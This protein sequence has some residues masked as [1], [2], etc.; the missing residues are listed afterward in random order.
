MEEK[1]EEQNF[2]FIDQQ[3]LYIELKKCG[4]IIDYVKFAR[5]LKEKYSVKRAYMF[6]GYIKGNERLYD[7]LNESGFECIFKPTMIKEGAIKGNCD[8]ELIL[9]AMRLFPMCDK[10][11]VVTSDGDFRCLVEYLI[12]HNKLKQL[13]VPN[14]RRY[15]ALLKSFREY[16]GYLNDME[17]RLKKESPHRDKTP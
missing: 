7:A 5:Y 14:G 3:N 6:L 10:I 8:S 11:V 16:T 12:F 1:K 17:K 13:L 15:S 2:A 4:W 9:H